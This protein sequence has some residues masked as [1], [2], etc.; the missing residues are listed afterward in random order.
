MLKLLVLGLLLAPMNSAQKTGANQQ[1]P[2]EW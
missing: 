1:M 2:A